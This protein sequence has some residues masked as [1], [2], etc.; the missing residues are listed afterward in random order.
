M[1]SHR[2]HTDAPDGL[3][4][5][6]PV[7]DVFAGQAV[8]D[9]LP[10]PARCAGL[11]PA[12]AV[13]VHRPSGVQIP[14]PPPSGTLERCRVC[15]TRPDPVALQRTMCRLS[16]GS[17]WATR[18][19]AMSQRCQMYGVVEDT[20]TRPDRSRMGRENSVESLWMKDF[21]IRRA[22]LARAAVS[23]R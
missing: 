12:N 6:Q 2:G 20:L 17:A 9:Q 21:P 14:E 22:D 8:F 18:A 16:R 15:E 10:P 13:W 23:A 11:N 7:P 19:S 5:A 3:G 4:P 1:R